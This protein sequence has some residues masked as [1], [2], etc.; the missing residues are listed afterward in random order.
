MFK[1]VLHFLT[2]DYTMMKERNLFFL[3]FIFSLF[4]RFP[5]FFRDYI[6]RDESTFILMGQ[7][8]VNGHLPYTELWDLKPPVIFLFFGAVIY[9]FGKSFIAIR[10]AG[11]LLVALTALFTY[12]VGVRA[13]SKKM[14][15]WASF[16]TVPLLSLFGS[17]QGV[18][19]EHI[20]IAF[21][22]MALYWSLFKRKWYWL[23]L[24]GIFY[25]LSFMSK[26]NIAYPIFFLGLFLCWEA[27]RDKR[28]MAEWPKWLLIVLG[29]VLVV[30][31]T[32]LPYLFSGELLIWW[33][34]V[35]EAPMAYSSS[36]TSSKLEAMVFFVLIIFFG[37]L[38]NRKKI[39]DFHQREVAIFFVLSLGMALSFVQIGKVNG[40]YLIQLYPFLL[41]LTFMAT[42]KI[43]LAKK[44][45]LKAI[46][47]LMLPLV[48]MEAYLEYA[49]IINHKVEK[50]TFYNGE[51]IEIPAYLIKNDLETENIFF[52]EYHIGY[53]LLGTNPPTKAATH[54]SNIARDALFPHMQNPRTTSAEELRYIMEEIRP[55]IIVARKGK[56]P[57][58]KQFIAL[59]FYVNIYLQKHYK[60]IKTIDRGLIYQRLE[61]L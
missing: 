55:S 21:F 9:F 56:R 48:P 8:W 45:Y 15:I 46:P 57:F 27:F 49:N 11:T 13:I 38:A 5:F 42:S 31:L 50:G 53:W 54:P 4:I 7:S 35:F 25:G 28:V 18:M 10:L 51:G 24:S 32:A 43:V 20:C 52:L 12:K 39:L 22:M 37:W 3:L 60:L 44:S 1:K 2:P 58:D 36:K 40:H 23:L 16:L 61:Q 41:I 29:M 14:A 19:S 47:L 6:D 17:L 26:L 59:N 34:S 33:Q 30:A